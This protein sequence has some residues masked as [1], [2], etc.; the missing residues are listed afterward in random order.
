MKRNIIYFFTAV[1]A[2]LGC[3]EYLDAKPDKALATISS[4]YDMQSLLD[5]YLRLNNQSAASAV[6]A[7]DDYYVK[8]AALNAIA[9]EG[10]KRI[11]HWQ[12]G[13]QF[14]G[15][16]DGWYYAYQAVYYGNAVIEH[17]T[18]LKRDAANEKEWDNIKGQAHF[19]KG[20]G[21]LFA[22]TIWAPAYEEATA[23]SILAVP[24]RASTD[25]NIKS[26]RASVAECYE[27]LLKDF[28]AAAQLL[29]VDQIHA[30]RPSKIAAYA[31]LSRAYLMMNKY[32]EAKLYA[33]SALSLNHILLDYNDLNAAA[34][35]PFTAYKG[36]VLCHLATANP[37][38]L[39]QSN[40]IVVDELY[41]AYHVDDLR[42]TVFF[43]NVGTNLY[44]FKGNYTGGNAQFLGP[45]VDEVYLNRA[46]SLARLN[47]LPLALDDLNSLMRK[48]WNK[49]KVY[50]PYVSSDQATVIGYVLTERRKELLMRGTRWTD[51]KRLNSLGYNIEIKRS[52]NSSLSTLPANDS[53]YVMSIPEEIIG[54]TGMP[55]NP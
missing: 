53:R 36:E 9:Q 35:N 50:T 28:K 43:R 16:L 18:E 5:D 3:K 17:I 37:P 49:A 7:S 29:P 46:E 44:T 8:D 54:L 10:D 1:M 42:K 6:I 13:N 11:Y 39:N 20:T 12:K 31:M 22:T 4:L 27:Q 45:A 19:F 26:T 51:L 47:Q 33:D 15:T 41:Q 30:M 52:Y 32:T 48:R 14:E 34:A 38:I 40:A 21:M 24:I 25:F 2:L 23:A 55:Q